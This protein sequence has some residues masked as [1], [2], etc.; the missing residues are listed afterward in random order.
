MSPNI[1]FTN[2]GSQ[3]ELFEVV[4]DYLE[5]VNYVTK[6]YRQAL[7]DR[8]EE[9]PTGLKVDLKDGSDILFAAIPHTEIQYCLVNQV[10]YVKNDKPL[11]FKHMINPEED[12]YVQDFFFIVNSKK[13][14]QTDILSNLITFF[15]TKGNLEHLHN[16]GDDKE[17]L[18]QY[19]TEKGVFTND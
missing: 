14:G 13:E 3:A 11:I 8:E 4:S 9:F 7:R 2:V 5:S 10:V 17:S 18:T 19:L 1:V 16:L 6:D 12:C 15:T